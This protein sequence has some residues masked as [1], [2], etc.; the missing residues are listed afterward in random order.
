MFPPLALAGLA[1]LLVVLAILFRVR[2]QTLEAAGVATAKAVASQ[3]LSLRQFYTAEIA[4][5]A[6]Q[7]GMR[8]DSDFDRH[9]GTL[10][11]PA[12]LVKALGTSI[13]RDY[14]GMSLRLYSRLPFPNRAAT[15]VYDDFE[16]RAL[17]EL[18]A[19]PERAQV[20]IDRSNGQRRV[21]YAVADRMQEGCVA[22]HNARSDSPRRDWK[23]GD[24]RGAIEITVPVEDVAG[25][26]E[27][28]I[29]SVALA[30]L[31]GFF[32]IGSVAA[33][34]T[35]RAAKALQDANRELEAHVDERTADLTQANA[36]LHRALQQV[37]HSEALA[38]LGSL[39]AGVAHE[40]GSPMGNA[41]TV[42]SALADKVK[43]LGVGVAEGKLRKSELDAF[44]ADATEAATLLRRNLD[45]AVKLMGEFKQVAADQTSVRRREFSLAELVTETLHTLSP[46]YKHYRVN[47][48]ADIPKD[49]VFDSYPGP[50]EQVIT[51]LVNNAVLHG[52]DGDA[53]LSV[54]IVAA[55][56]SDGASVRLTFSD[57]GRGMSADV[58]AQA[59]EPF[60]TTRLGSG[61]TGLGLHL[62]RKL[63]QETLGGRL[64]MTSEPGKGTR[65]YITLPRV[66]PVATRA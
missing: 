19:N 25:E 28:G 27:R 32:A 65:F 14:P 37:E 8:L 22:C 51:N 66:A 41:S 44:I 35:R 15:E 10:P 38:A 54:K 45:R 16:I 50:L 29:R 52:R 58:V 59:F 6:G 57:T 40:L 1:M 36:Y 64:E 62:V 60:F 5:R 18:E 33:L 56:V 46:G 31:V 55:L 7:A 4:T 11:L 24:V 3:V 48:S 17:A 39:V 42:A 2:E 26:V 23:V 43:A 49:I 9:A 34:A 63:V 30:V 13:E 53:V 21:R 47:V 61:G 20:W 12:T